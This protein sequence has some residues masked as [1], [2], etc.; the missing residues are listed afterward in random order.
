VSRTRLLVVLLVVVVLIQI[1]P[2]RAG[3]IEAMA[4]GGAALVA[5]VWA[6]TKG[7]ARYKSKSL[8]AAQEAANA[9]EY[10]QYEVELNAIRAKYD[11]H[12]DLTE[13]TSISQEYKDELSALHDRHEAMLARK[14]GSSR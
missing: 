13:P 11:P 9:E 8:R 7:F 1:Y 10:R 2:E 6:I 4:V 12:R 14:F 5:L 3:I